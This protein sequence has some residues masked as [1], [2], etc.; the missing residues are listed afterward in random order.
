MSKC[1]DCKDFLRYTDILTGKKKQS[2]FCTSEDNYRTVNRDRVVSSR[3]CKFFY[4]RG[5]VE[6]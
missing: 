3:A 1:G 2:G 5:K 4:Q 6:K